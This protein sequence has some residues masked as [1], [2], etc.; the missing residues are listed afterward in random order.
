MNKELITLLDYWE[1]EKGIE[2]GLLLNTLESGLLAVYRKKAGLS[3]DVNIKIDPETG[4]IRFLDKAGQEL[5]PPEFPW[6]RIAAQTAKH[7]ILQKLRETEKFTVYQDFKK[8]EGTIVSGRVER[9]EDNNVIVSVGKIETL[10]PSIHKIGNEHFRQGEP[11]KVYVLE[12]RKPNKGTYQVI[13]SR[14]HP[15]FAKQLLQ[16][17]VPEVRD[18][19]IK[20]K[21]VARFPGDMVKIAVT[22]T[23]PR[24]DAIGTCVGEN[25]RRIKNMMKELKGEKVEVIL[26][27]KDVS[28]YI[29]NSLSPAVGKEVITDQTKKEAIV[30]TDD[31]QLFLAIGK[32][33]QNVRLAS[34][35]TGWNIRVLRESEYAMEKKPAVGMIEGIEDKI[36]LELAKFGY[37]SIKSLAEADIEDIKKIP[38]IED[39]LAEKIVNKAREYRR[40]IAE[41]AEESEK[42]ENEKNPGIPVTGED[43]R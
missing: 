39:E 13:V 43:K 32:R 21:A 35:L 34:K 24:I 11:V 12:V 3:E 20:I 5:P 30:I 25:A 40:K 1:K 9:F 16:Q 31:N 28:K 4:D 22:S 14:T 36:A 7:V 26:W 33:G 27:D 41:K 42:S 18:G 37:S 19:I 6:K 8:L 2:K 29:M 38:A 17:E 10:L 15:D 23:D